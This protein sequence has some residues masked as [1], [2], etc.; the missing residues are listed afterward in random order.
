MSFRSESLPEVE[1]RG[2]YFRKSPI[3]KALPSIKINAIYFFFL[4]S[5]DTQR[6][7]G[8]YPSGI[9]EIKTRNSAFQKTE[10]PDP[11]ASPYTFGKVPPQVS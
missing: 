3:S 8:G 11:R 9:M 10:C 7:S 1:P 5:C 6:V 4:C 2:A